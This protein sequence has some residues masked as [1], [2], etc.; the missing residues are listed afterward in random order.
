[1]T[2]APPSAS[3]GP[4]PAPYTPRDSLLW[5][6]R[7]GRSSITLLYGAVALLVLRPEVVLAWVAAI[8][9]WQLFIRPS[10]DRLLSRM[11]PDRAR[12]GLVIVNLVAASLHQVLTLLCLANGS[13]LG[14]AVATSWVGAGALF[15]FVTFKGDRWLLAAMLGPMLVAVSAG[16][17]LAYGLGSQALVMG[18]LLALGLASS[19][20]VLAQLADRE[21]ALAHLD[22]KLAVTIEASGDGFFELDLVADTWNCGASWWAMLGY[23]RDE[24]DASIRGWRDVIHPDDHRQVSEAYAAHFRGELELVAIEIRL[25]CKDGG[26]KWVLSRAKLV[27]RAP[28]GR[29]WHVV[30]TNVDLTG[31]KALEHQLEASLELAESAN[32]AKSV[33][34][35]NMSHEIR[36][37]LNGVMG[38]AG[39]LAQTPLAGLQR[40]MVGLIQSSGA[41]LERIL[42]DILDQAKVEAGNFQLQTAPF[43]LRAEIEGVA[44]LMRAPAEEKGLTLRLDFTRAADGLFDGDAVR[45]K[46]VVSNLASNAIKFTPAGEVAIKVAVT[47]RRD[48]PSRLRVEVSDTG[49]GFDG[50]TAGRL[51]G[52]FVQADGSTSRRFGGTGL[53]LSICKALVELMGGEVGAR[54]KPG[55][56]SLFWIEI[57]LRRTV[58]LAQYRR[59]SAAAPAPAKATARVK[60]LRILLAEDHPTNQ[61]VVQLILE[62]MGVE[63][64]VVGDGQAALKAFEPGRFDLILMDMQMP[65]MDGLE[66]TR[67]I[68]E[69]EAASGAHPVP[70]A[71]FT[72]NAMDDHRAMARAA[73]AD[74]HIAKPITPNSLVTGIER[75]LGLAAEPVSQRA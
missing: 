9:I 41:M 39:A 68:R 13:P 44:A 60:Q 55:F 24:R 49:I 47:Q 71:M 61:R 63:L 31:R 17:L 37:P 36:T 34:I 52:R 45:I 6:D 58:P 64:S 28:D 75:A 51:F 50:E 20:K 46:Q 67:A 57:P 54:S 43:D 70:I 30:G 8:L 35:A 12:V 38:V 4:A 11:P 59:G 15:I 40:E 27:S 65:L 32:R 25:R 48:E 56:G 29:P 53:G 18:L 3:L 7:L 22:R 72:A 62:P 73:G 14:V 23:G 19:R 2:D 66:A 69:R 16:P 74:H 5:R 33:F 42:S 1:M 10:F 26:F 21:G